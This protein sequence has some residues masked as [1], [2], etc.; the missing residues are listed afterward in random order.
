LIRLVLRPRQAALDTSS[1]IYLFPNAI[2]TFPR[3]SSSYSPNNIDNT[4]DDNNTAPPPCIPIIS[5][6]EYLLP[7]T[8]NQPVSAATYSQTL[9]DFTPIAQLVILRSISLPFGALHKPPNLNI[10]E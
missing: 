2:A 7:L 6:G 1:C 3:L 9:T 8:Y 4:N 10:V 5:N